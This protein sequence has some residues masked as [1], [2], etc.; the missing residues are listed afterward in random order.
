MLALGQSACRSHFHQH[1]KLA[2]TLTE[3]DKCI[4]VAVRALEDVN[5]VMHHQMQYEKT[6][7]SKGKLHMKT[8]MCMLCDDNE[9]A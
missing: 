4:V 7:S 6:R 5:G 2:S 9:N 8:R 1:S 3:D